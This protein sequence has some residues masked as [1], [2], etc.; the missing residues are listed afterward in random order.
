MNNLDFMNMY[1]EAKKGK[2]TLW[3]SAKD[4]SVFIFALAVVV[5]LIIIL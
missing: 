5:S 4:A 2:Y 3:E 1:R